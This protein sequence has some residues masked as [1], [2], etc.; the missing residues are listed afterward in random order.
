MI[1]HA[2]SCFLL[3]GIVLAG[4]VIEIA[5]KEKTIVRIIISNSTGIIVTF[6]ML[7]F[8]MWVMLDK[9]FCCIDTAIQSDVKVEYPDIDS[10]HKTLMGGFKTATIIIF[11]WSP[12]FIIC[13]PTITRGYDYFWQL[14]QGMGL[15]PLSNHHPVFGSFIFGSL[16]KTGYTIGGASFGLALTTIVQML[17]MSLSMGFA[18]AVVRII[19]KIPNRIYIALVTY[20]CLCPV[21]PGHAVW[22]IKDVIFTAVT[23]FMFFQF[24]LHIWCVSN[25]IYMPV[26]ASLPFFTLS[27][28]L[29][30]LFRNGT[31]PI[32]GVVFLV[33][34]FF[35]LKICRKKERALKSSAALLA[36]LIIMILWSSLMSAM[37]VYPT[38]SREALALPARQVIRTL[39]VHPE[40][41]NTESEAILNS[42]YHEQVANGRD[43]KSI[44][45]SYDDYNADFIKFDYLSDESI[46]KDFIHYWI[47]LGLRHPGSYLDALMRGT[48]GYWYYG[49]NPHLEANG[50]I[51]HTVCT[52]GPEDDFA[53]DTMIDKRLDSLFLPTVKSL[54]QAGV[55]TDRTFR[56]LCGEN[57]WLDDLMH[58]KSA[59]PSMRI[60]LGDFLAKLENNTVIALALAP[61]TYFFILIVCFAYMFERRKIGRFLWP[62]ILLEVLAWLSPINGYTRYVLPVELISILLIGVCFTDESIRGTYAEGKKSKLD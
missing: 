18:F 44:M 24:L 34:I 9:L 30:S 25:S 62:V 27:A 57:P 37:H 12:Y 38:N 53:N 29:F 52:T 14:L 10:I 46:M 40:E 3:A 5:P 43:I 31:A 19:T 2:L 55:D 39:K 35:D 41:M 33:L 61:G 11:S 21:F 45:D 13:Y 4:L 7:F 56:E 42:L 54:E 26:I 23:I 32:A 6:G 28:V 59:F 17:L 1:W 22:A 16:F 49:K 20:V 48:D 50:I 47:R 15:F 60:E 36:Y 58:V 51:Y 8:C